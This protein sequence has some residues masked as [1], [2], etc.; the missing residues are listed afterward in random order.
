M[1]PRSSEPRQSSESLSEDQEQILAGLPLDPVDPD[2]RT[3]PTDDGEIRPSNTEYDPTQQRR[4]GDFPPE[5]VGR[6]DPT[7]PAASGHQYPTE[8]AR[9]RETSSV[10]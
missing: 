6:T 10:E 4:S 9:S 5:G 7:T 2:V 8:L 3:V 1:T